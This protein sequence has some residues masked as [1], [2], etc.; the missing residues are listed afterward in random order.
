[1]NHTPGNFDSS[2]ASSPLGGFSPFGTQEVGSLSPFSATPLVPQSP[3]AGIPDDA[4]AAPIPEPGKPAKIPAPRP[5]VQL[6][7]F[8]AV[9]DAASPFGFEP[10]AP[11]IHSPFS[12]ATPFPAHA[13]P[14]PA[15]PSPFPSA[16]AYTAPVAPPPAPAPA[17]APLPAHLPHTP[18]FTPPAP[19]TITQ[20]APTGSLDNQAS[21]YRQLELRAIFGIDREMNADEIIHRTRSLPGIRHV[22]RIPFQDLAS[23]DALKKSLHS[24]GI[25]A[26]SL[27]LSNGHTSIDF[28]RHGQTA[29]AVQVDG[30]FA[31]GVRETIMIVA[32]E[33]DKL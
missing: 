33:L 23:L 10:V 27:R 20:P 14:R 31:P 26:E 1:M 3:F 9:P 5:K 12:V 11:G 28:F 29:L 2:A 13:S 24:L 8:E 7:P 18:A 16:N 17:P 22:T 19:H 25:P 30:A 4:S 32:R 21:A 6:S 15:F